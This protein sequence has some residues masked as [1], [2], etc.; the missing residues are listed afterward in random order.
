MTREQKRGRLTL[1]ISFGLIL[2][3]NLGIAALIIAFHVE[4]PLRAGIRI[5]FSFAL[6]VGT[7]SG[8]AW[9]KWLLIVLSL[10]AGLSI[11]SDFFSQPSWTRG[12]LLF[13]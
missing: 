4:S 2:L 1:L 11:G 8:Q 3:I 6:M 5:V 10:L 9:A 7:Y 12:L 13:I